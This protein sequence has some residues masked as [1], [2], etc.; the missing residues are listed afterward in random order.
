MLWNETKRKRGFGFVEFNDNDIVD[1]VVLL[2]GHNINGYELDCKKALSKDEMRV[3]CMTV[4]FLTR[5]RGI[6]HSVSG[7]RWEGG[8]FDARPKPRHN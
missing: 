4:F 6:T 2:G 5:F 1:K 3:S 8:G 7:R